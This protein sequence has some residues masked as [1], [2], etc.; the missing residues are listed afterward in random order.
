MVAGSSLA[1]S[2]RVSSAT[3]VSRYRMGTTWPCLP[4]T[5]SSLASPATGSTSSAQNHA[6]PTGE[7]QGF[8][9]DGQPLLP[10]FLK[11]VGSFELGTASLLQSPRT[12]YIT[13][14]L[15]MLNVS[16][17]SQLIELALR[18]YFPHGGLDCL[19]LPFD[20]G[21]DTALERW[22]AQVA[23]HL[24]SLTPSYERTVVLVV[25]HTDA[26]T[27]DFFLGTDENGI[28]QAAEVDQFAKY[29]LGPFAN[30]LKGS[31]VY[32]VSC[33]SVVNKPKSFQKLCVAVQS[34]DVCHALAF[35]APHLQAL[36]TAEL[37]MRLTRGIVVHGYDFVKCLEENLQE[38]SELGRHS[39]VLH[40]HQGTVTRY[41]WA[42]K[43]IQPWGQ[44]NPVQCPQC[45][46]FQKWEGVCLSGR[47]YSFECNNELCGNEDVERY[48]FVVKRPEC[49]ILHNKRQTPWAWLK[50][51]VV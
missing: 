15:A 35:D 9:R 20:V 48:G 12:L 41:T 17:V 5:S 30:Y 46:V 23:Q 32:F 43:N 25:N 21:A 45:G 33:G 4:T 22:P 11:V 38:V 24:E 34:F 39:A 31:T 10:S 14:H 8:T 2:A 29:V 13:L 3:V 27:G 37:L 49:T 47:D 36:T 51:V 42:H 18:E 1:T 44:R 28:K 6:L 19:V 26:D 50:V 40:F 16:T 7:L